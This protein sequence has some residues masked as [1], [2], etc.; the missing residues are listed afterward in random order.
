M[1]DL[2]T[3]KIVAEDIYY[4]TRSSIDRRNKVQGYQVRIV[5]GK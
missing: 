3:P 2:Y 1:V 5:F 4:D